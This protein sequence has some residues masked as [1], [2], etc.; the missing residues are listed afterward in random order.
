ML[1]RSLAPRAVVR[2]IARRAEIG[3]GQIYRRRQE[4]VPAKVSRRL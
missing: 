2:E 4:L 1:P 3:T